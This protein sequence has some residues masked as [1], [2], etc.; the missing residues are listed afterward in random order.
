M[1]KLLLSLSLLLFAV[2]TYGQQAQPATP[3]QQTATHVDSCTYA[4]ASGATPQTLTIAAPPAG[5]SV[6]ITELD[7][8]AWTTAAPTAGAGTIT[9]AGFTNN[10]V[11]TF[12]FAATANI[13]WNPS[14]MTYPTG[15]KA[16]ANTAV[17][18]TTSTFAS[19][20]AFIHACYYYGY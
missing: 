3:V 8:G 14:A 12:E 15:M 6:Y 5:Q 7:M 13:N 18:Y 11:W 1:K 10:P 9:A 4:Q 19:V 17:T 16:L 20:S 2:A